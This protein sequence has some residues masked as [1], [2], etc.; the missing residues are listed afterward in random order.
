[1]PSWQSV[2]FHDALKILLVVYVDDL[3]MAGP[4]GALGK[5]WDMIRGDEAEN[6]LRIEPPEPFGLFLG[7]SHEVGSVELG[8]GKPSV[9]TMTYNVEAYLRKSIDKYLGVLPAGSALK[10]APT[11]FLAATGEAL[12]V[13]RPSRQG[14]DP[15]RC[16]WCRGIFDHSEFG[17]LAD[18]KKVP[19]PT[20][21]ERPPPRGVLAAKAA[22]V[23]MQILYAARYARFDLLCAVSKLAQR[24]ATWDEECDRGIYRLM[25][26]IQSTL[27]WRQM[28]YVGDGLSDVVF[29]LYADADFA[30]DPS[31]K[32]TSGMHVAISGPRTYFPLNGQSKRQ[33]CVSH[34]TPEAEIV[35][36]DLALRREGLPMLDLWD[37]LCP[38]HAPLRFHED[39]EAMIR[40]CRSGRNPTMRHL[41]RT[42]AVAVASLHETFSRSDITLL[43]VQSDRQAADIYTKA[44]DNGDKWRAVCTL[45]GVYDV[46]S[47]TVAG[48]IH[49]WAN[50]PPT[51]AALRAEAEEAAVPAPRGSSGSSAAFCGSSGPVAPPPHGRG[52]FGGPGGSGGISRVIIE[53]CCSATSTI[54]AVAPPSC[55][56]FRIT[57]VD[58]FR[59]AKGRCKVSRILRRFSHH[60]V[61]IWVSFPCTGGS[62]WQRQNWRKG[63]P[64]TQEKIRSHWEDLRRLW[65]SFCSVVLPW[66][67]SG[68]VDLAWE[69]PLACSYWHWTGE[70]RCPDGSHQVAI[71]DTLQS[72]NMRS[73]VV[74]GCEVGLV[75]HVGPRRGEH[76]R[77]LW[78]VDST[79]RS[80]LDGIGKPLRDDRSHLS[81]S[82]GG[83]FH[84]VRCEGS[85]TKASEIYPDSFA[86]AIHKGWSRSCQ[87]V[88]GKVRTSACAMPF[89]V[90]QSTGRADR[91]PPALA[92]P[93]APAPRL[94]A[95]PLDP[96]VNPGRFSVLR[97]CPR[98]ESVGPV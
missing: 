45:I 18:P 65:E 73:M 31:K 27:S 26:Y 72:L 46:S 63:N 11:P 29:D 52:D 92:H 24:I 10:K 71:R 70:G 56:V 20:P 82:H 43:Y 2:Y 61:L 35:A 51:K 5:C 59:C 22:S 62:P 87:R 91:Q 67:R 76:V 60:P 39:N 23:L 32:S 17:Q 97:P 85:I 79:V 96:R 30:G 42:H 36:A 34:S 83:G 47:F 98:T 54:G 86:R 53:I 19:A 41:L 12:D 57:V 28:G 16:P 48:N 15:K 89:L 81:C 55:R 3:K 1:M 13:A 74:H 33:D 40:V 7:C 9:K 4:K 66:V 69:W 75:A 84:H 64:D 90:Q 78:R 21:A 25:C 93:C 68:K 8:A 38:G 50:P 94:R 95:T 14:G 80:L 88:R 77:K 37:V 49:F 58:D 6:G 44:F